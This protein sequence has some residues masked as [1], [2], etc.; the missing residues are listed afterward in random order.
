MNKNYPVSKALHDRAQKSL[1][2]GVNS[3]VRSFRRVG[4]QPLMAVRGEGSYLWDADGNRYI[5]TVM[6]YG[7]H[8]FGHAHPKVCEAVEKAMKNSSCLGMSSEAEIEW[9]E[10][11]LKRLPKAEKVRAMSTG[12]EACAT[13]IRLARGYTKRDKILKFSGHYHGHV[14]SLMVAAGSGLATLAEASRPVPDSAGI[15]KALTDLAVVSEFNNLTLL[16]EVFQRHGNEFAAAILEPVMGNMGVIPPDPAFLRELRELTRSYGAVLIFDEVM[17]GLRVGRQ[18]AQGLYGIDPDLTCL[19]KIIGG[20]LPLSALAG[21][22]EIMDH[23]APL[24]PVYQAGT[25][26]GNPVSIAAGI[27]MMKLIDS[28]DP[29]ERLETFGAKLQGWITNEA[30]RC[31]LPVRVE[32]VAS[33]ISVF[34]R[35]DKLRND[36]DALATDGNLFNQYFWNMLDEGFMLPPS[37]YE[38][39]FLATSHLELGDDVWAQG[40]RRV[41][42]RIRA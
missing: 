26:S 10:L 35:Q 8:L 23:L 42:E 11:L 29:Y 17:T 33:M 4:G 20:G 25:L 27:A 6:S 30:D 2:G 14:D 28:E 13:A 5:D 31:R 40:L 36:R 37:P 16:E 22:A 9:A 12:T 19:G 1:V 38:A 32:R 24:G 41:F 7:P 34:F 21:R 3:P 18:S 15:P 39:C